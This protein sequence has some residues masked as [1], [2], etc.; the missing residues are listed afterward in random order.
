MRICASYLLPV[1]SLFV[2][3]LNNIHLHI[4]EHTISFYRVK[5]SDMTV[6]VNL[7]KKSKKKSLTGMQEQEAMQFEYHVSSQHKGDW[8]IER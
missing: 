2:F 7:M 1:V 5:I 3:F 8:D 4:S 6:R